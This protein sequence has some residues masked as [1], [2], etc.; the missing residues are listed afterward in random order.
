M[1]FSKI[2]N[3]IK[4]QIECRSNLVQTVI[5]HA[6]QTKIWSYMKHGTL[7]NKFYDAVIFK[8]MK[9]VLG[10]RI[11]LMISGGAPLQMEIKTFLTVVFS[12]PIFEAYGMTEAAGNISC[13]A[14]WDR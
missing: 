13:T 5:D 14:Y 10:G 2:Y 6:I 11:R 4:E 1:F 9:N 3:K 8:A 12:A 7:T